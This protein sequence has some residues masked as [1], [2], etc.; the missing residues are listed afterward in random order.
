MRGLIQDERKAR[1][2]LV[3]VS[4]EF[5]LHLGVRRVEE[6]P[7]YMEV[8]QT[9]LDGVLAVKKRTEQQEA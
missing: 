2:R 5:L 9:V 3:S 7:D 1:E 8:R 4:V 6:L